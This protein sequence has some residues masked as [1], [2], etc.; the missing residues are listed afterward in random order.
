[1]LK[2]LKGMALV[3]ALALCAGCGGAAEPSSTRSGT[4]EGGGSPQA[5]TPP[6][7]SRIGVLRHGLGARAKD[8]PD[9]QWKS[10]PFQAGNIQVRGG[11]CSQAETL[12]SDAHVQYRCRTIDCH[13][14]GYRCV[15][16]DAFS[17]TASGGCVRG[18]EAVT[19]T[20]S[21]GY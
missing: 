21:G 9:R 17:G 4:A 7:A 6:Q 10:F 12:V 14:D 13:V 2:Q 1:M 20:F 18:D 11:S 16:L 5:Q 8:C 15:N 19:W 3:A